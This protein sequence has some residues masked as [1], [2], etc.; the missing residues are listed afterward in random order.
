MSHAGIEN[1]STPHLLPYTFATQKA[2]LGVSAFQLRD[3][4]GHGNLV[5]TQLYV[6]LGQ[7]E[8]RRVMEETS[9]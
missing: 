6:H 5:T 7:E 2:R 8:A 9:L 4:L 1:W 3:Y